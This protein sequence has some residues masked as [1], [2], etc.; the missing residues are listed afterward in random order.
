LNL[1]SAGFY[2]VSIYG[3]ASGTAHVCIT[4]GLLSVLSTM[5]YWNR[6]T[7]LWVSAAN[8]SVSN[9]FPSPTICG[10]IPVTALSGTPIAIGI[11]SAPDTGAHLVSALESITLNSAT[12]EYVA[13]VSVTNTGGDT[14]K[15]VTV[16]ASKLNDLRTST[17]LPISVG[18]I[19]YAATVPVVLTF[20]ARGSE[21]EDFGHLRIVE[22]YT[23]GTAEQFLRVKLPS[24]GESERD[25]KDRETQDRNHPSDDH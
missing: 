23:G 17:N 1:G 5:R 25:D 8:I 14:A 4:G 16:T 24:R 3:I 21:E 7:S 18:D 2:D 19:S 11:P 12:D 22:T 20:S 13:L 6:S 15:G 10:D 9:N